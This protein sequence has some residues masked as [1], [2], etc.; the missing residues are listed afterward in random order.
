M[1]NGFASRHRSILPG[2]QKWN[3]VNAL[4]L[5]FS[6]LAGLLGF[7]VCIASHRI[8]NRHGSE[9]KI[10]AWGVEHDSHTAD[11]RMKCLHFVI[12]Y[13]TWKWTMM[14]HVS[15]LSSALSCAQLAYEGNDDCLQ[16]EMQSLFELRM[17]NSLP[18]ITIISF[19]A[20][21]S[22][23]TYIIA[24]LVDNNHI[25]TYKGLSFRLVLLNI[26]LSVRPYPYS[27]YGDHEE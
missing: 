26:F 3:H 8:G 14:E 7:Y 15:L 17:T 20:L 10:S 2:E 4:N 11:I 22:I 13:I 9:E 25:L 24:P 1:L 23:E 18:L 5:S 16:G 27:K 12:P 21:P 19:V 6:S